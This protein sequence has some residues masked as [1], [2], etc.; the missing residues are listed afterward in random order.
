MKTIWIINQFAGYPKVGANQRHFHLIQYWQSKGNKLVL[1]SNSNNHLIAPENHSKKGL[2]IEDGVVFYWIKTLKHTH[3][4]LLRFV[5]MIE[6]AFRVGGLIFKRK[7]LGT[8][9]IIILSCVSIFPMLQVLF[10]KWYFRADKFIYEIRDLWPLTPILL[11]GF[12]KW[13][14]LILYIAWLEKLG[15]RKSQ[16]IVSLL[17]G[18][19]RYINPI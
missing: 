7:Q 12:S 2:I 13:N 8:P 14:P 16:E 15:Y 9:N 5:S 18:S 6:F 1:I 3:K 11:M 10:L 17:D 19:E 4:S